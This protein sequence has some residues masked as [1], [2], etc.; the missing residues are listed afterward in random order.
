MINENQ[1]EFLKQHYPIKGKK[2]CMEKL[3]LKEW[4]V[5]HWASKLG[6][7]LDVNSNFYKEF[8][9]RAKVSKRGIKKPWLSKVMKEKFKRGELPQLNN[10]HKHGLSKTK[11][12]S[13]WS[14]M[15][16]RCYSK[17]NDGYIH[18][19]ARG[20]KVCKEWQD[21]EVFC[22]W[23]HQRYKEGLTIERIDYNGNYE[24]NNCTFATVSDQAR[25]RRTTKLNKDKVKL[26]RNMY[27]NNISQVKIAEIIGISNQTVSSVVNHQTWKN[28]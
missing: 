24:P 11:G 1:I 21:V 23:F 26:I 9:E 19:G 22:K 27:H 4:E 18:Y 2:W 10:N 20:I 25:N 28:I 16:S 7:K 12:Y 15:M 13:A 14:S 17:S 3:N 8:Q 5:R 6:L